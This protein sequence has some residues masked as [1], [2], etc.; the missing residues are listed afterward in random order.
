MILVIA[1]GW[2]QFKTKTVEVDSI[3][4]DKDQAAPKKTITQ[5]AYLPKYQKS[6]RVALSLV[7]VGI[8]WGGY[9]LIQ[10]RQIELADQQFQATQQ[11]QATQ[12]A[13]WVQQIQATQ[14]ALA[15]QQA[16]Q[17]QQAQATQYS[18]ATAQAQQEMENKLVVVIA[19]FEGP[20]EVYGVR[21][22]IVESLNSAFAQDEE[23]K[24][25][26]VYDVVTPDMSSSYA[27]NL[28]KQYFADLVIWG[29]YRPTENPNIT[30]HI[31]N[32]VS[33]ANRIHQ[34]K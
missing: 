5:P 26:T 30:V 28:G 14:N 21:N 32:S 11:V 31:E 6:A 8:V 2:V 25:V 33:H 17:T 12:T 7:I 15:T 10:H 19:T 9:S 27:R 1:L 34:R 23:V 18:Q 4:I 16:S 3:L 13:S 24:I 29:W 20:E 22:E